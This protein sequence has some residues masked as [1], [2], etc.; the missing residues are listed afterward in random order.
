MPVFWVSL[1][2]VVVSNVLYHVGQKSVPGGAHPILSVLVSYVVALA[3]TLLLV[4]FFPLKG[5][6]LPAIKA[7]K[8]PSVLVGI[9]IVGI[10]VG[11]LLAYRAG[12]RIGLTSTVV[13]AAL[14][15]L[16][17]PM[18]IAFYGERLTGANVAGILLCV[19]GLALVA[20]R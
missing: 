5:P 13:A 1:I 6:L 19:V 7:L 18:G 8:W 16:L 10:E 12:W 15:V 17:I 4:P 3:A 11:F 9:S 2:L 14:A 20:Q